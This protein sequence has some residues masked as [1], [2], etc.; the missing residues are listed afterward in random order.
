M[1]YHQGLL[2]LLTFIYP[3]NPIETRGLFLKRDLFTVRSKCQ[4]EQIK[5]LK[6]GT[7]FQR[8]CE[9]SQWN[10]TG[11]LQMMLERVPGCRRRVSYP[12]TREKRE[13]VLFVIGPDAGEQVTHFNS[14]TDEKLLQML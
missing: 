11:Q 7:T 10:Q 9:M 8:L 5:T 12:A 3:G 1:K 2:L 6:T 14:L 4:K 13:K